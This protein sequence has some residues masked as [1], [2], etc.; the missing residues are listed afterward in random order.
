LGIPKIILQ[1]ITPHTVLFLQIQP[2]QFYKNTFVCVAKDDSSQGTIYAREKRQL[3]VLDLVA[4]ESLLH[5][6]EFPF[7]FFVPSIRF[8]SVSAS[9]HSPL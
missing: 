7:P 4:Y 9:S 2:P 6:G 8:F 5:C 3:F 1:E